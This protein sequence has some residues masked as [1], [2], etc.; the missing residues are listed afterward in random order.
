M[1]LE[2]STAGRTEVGPLQASTRGPL[3]ASEPTS[4][5]VG[6]DQLGGVVLG[7]DHHQRAAVE[8]TGGLGP[9][10]ELPHPVHRRLAR[11]AV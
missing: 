5:A 7:G 6:D 10:D 3:Q 9:V 1:S 8:L 11:R 4:L 2:R